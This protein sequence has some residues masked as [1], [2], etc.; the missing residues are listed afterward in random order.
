LRETIVG[1]TPDRDEGFTDALAASDRLQKWSTI[2]S[3]SH[4]SRSWTPPHSRR[5]YEER[6]RNLRLG[7]AIN[8]DRGTGLTSA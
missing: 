4:G 2:R 7:E 5:R 1:K 3:R 6:G 8:R